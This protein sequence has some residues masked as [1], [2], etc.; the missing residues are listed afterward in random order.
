LFSKTMRTK[1]KGECCRVIEHGGSPSTL[2]PAP[3]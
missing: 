1:K 2:G 3:G